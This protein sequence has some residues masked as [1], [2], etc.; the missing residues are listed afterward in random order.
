MPSG[1]E[2]SGLD[3]DSLFLPLGAFTPISNVNYQVSG[4]D[5]SN[6]YAPASA[7]S[8]YGPVNIK[9]AGV[10][11]GTL[12]ASKATNTL[13]AGTGI[14]S[15][16]GQNSGLVSSGGTNYT[17]TAG[18]FHPVAGVSDYGYLQ[19]TIGAISPTN[20]NGLTIPALFTTV[21]PFT[22]SYQDQ[23]RV[24]YSTDPGSNFFNTITVGSIV[25]SSASAT[26]SYTSGTATW[27]WIGSPDTAGLFNSTGTYNV[28]I[29]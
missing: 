10:D 12:F 13:I 27:S 8:P 29:S 22:G 2:A 15:I 21:D 7:G 19:G 28:A 14:Y 17:L 25:R 18:V 4:T 26:Y 1:I 9:S 3:L 20:F 6:R 24:L 16:A 5:I 11:I 23:F